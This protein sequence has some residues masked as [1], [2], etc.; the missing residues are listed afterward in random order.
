[1]KAVITLATMLFT[2]IPCH[3][4]S[5]GPATHIGEAVRYI[6]MLDENPLEGPKGDIALLSDP[7]LLAYFKLG[8]TFPDI[9]RQLPGFCRDPHDEP[10]AYYIFEKGVAEGSEIPW[11]QAFG[12]GYLMHISGDISAQLFVTER[13][14]VLGRWGELSIFEGVMDDHPGGENELL[15]EAWLEIEFADLAEYFGLLTFFTQGARLDEV[16]D[17]YNGSFTEFCD[18]LAA[19]DVDLHRQREIVLGKMQSWIDFAQDLSGDPLHD[20][21]A[22]LR[23]GIG[24]GGENLVFDRQAGLINERELTRL[25][26]GPTYSE[27]EF[28]NMYPD[29]YK[30][31]GPT[32]LR[33]ME[34]GEN[35]Y[36]IWPTWSPKVMSAASIASLANFLPDVYSPNADIIAWDVDWTDGEGSEISEV[37]AQNLPDQICCLVKMFA[38]AQSSHDVT[39]RIRKHVV[40]V[41]PAADPILGS[42]SVNIDHNPYEYSTT[43]LAEAQ[44][45]VDPA[46]DTDDAWGYVA[47]LV[48]ADSPTKPFF[49]TNFEAFYSIGEI[50]IL[51]LASYRALYD[52]YEKWPGSIRLT[53]QQFP[54]G[55]YVL[56]GKVVDASTGYNAPAAQI[57]VN[58]SHIVDCNANGYFEIGGLPE[59]QTTIAPVSA[60][61]YA[62]PEQGS[63]FEGV[64]GDNL[65]VEV[66]ME[67]KPEVAS[68]GEYYPGNAELAVSW[69][70]GELKG[71]EYYFE[72]AV[73]MTQGADDV[74]V[75]AN[76]GKTQGAAIEFNTPVADGTQVFAS[77]RVS[78]G[79]TNYPAGL[80]DGVIMDGSPPASPVVDTHPRQIDS[81]GASVNITLNSQDAHSQIAGYRLAVGYGDGP[82]MLIEW[83]DADTDNDVDIPAIP[84]DAGWVSVYARAIN[85]AGL[86]SDVA[87]A[88]ISVSPA[89]ANDDAADD[90]TAPDDD[91]DAHNEDDDIGADSDDDDDDDGGCG[92]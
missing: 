78:N 3:A 79:V 18:G 41:D 8:A 70:A 87:V 59:G 92:C 84:E 35:W 6:E 77:V 14:A 48:A 43:N 19:G 73:G 5:Y 15:T 17:F 71:T 50:D 91:D 53:G 69:Q 89:D 26:E 55:E 33:V 39:L 64:A 58:D 34:P 44:V 9:G 16:L 81:A 67:P 80:S 54:L 66:A 45:C 61:Y 32:I 52:T 51:G 76:V 57:L 21:M 10:F 22:A 49:T 27:P 20:I 12:L 60:P 74:A 68:L 13:F 40:G 28:W 75:W 23:S 85:G 30:D 36:D 25:L 62:A 72:A 65:Y 88:G 83:M 7:E 4:L 37:D 38:V 1:M 29:Q 42:E 86:I 24:S 46:G 90:D 47:D 82:T 2:L 56:R 11:K 31:L 63:V